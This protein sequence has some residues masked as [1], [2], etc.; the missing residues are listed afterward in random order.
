MFGHTAEV[1]KKQKNIRTKW[2]RVQQKQPLP[3]EDLIHCKVIQLH[4]NISFYLSMIYGQN[5]EFQREQLWLDLKDISQS[6]EEA[7]CLM[8]DFNSVISKDDRIGGNEVQDHKLRELASLLESCALHEPKSTGAY[9]SW[10]NRTI[11]SRIDHVFLNDYWY[12][13]FDYTH[14]CYMTNSLSNHALLV[15]QLPS[16]PKPKATF[17]YSDMLS[18][19]HEFESIINSPQNFQCTSLMQTLYQYLKLIRPLLRRLNKNYFSDLKEQQTSARKTLELIQLETQK[20]LEDAFRK[21]QE[22]EAHDKYI[23]ILSSSMALI[24]QQCKLEWINY[25]DDCSR[26]FFAK[27]K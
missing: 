9:F 21:Q 15:V 17:Q 18:K 19:H 6:M 11:W 10:T 24:K 14:S 2:R 22:K 4:S 25:G 27:A 16:S 20:Y 7:W 3:P 8:G 26:L 5:H 23:S 12:E 1:Y 13:V